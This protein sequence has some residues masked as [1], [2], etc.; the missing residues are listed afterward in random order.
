MTWR[1][2]ETV[3]PLWSGLSLLALDLIRSFY[4]S[5]SLSFAAGK[6]SKINK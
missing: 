3:A 1:G 5:E 6:K 4:L 2:E